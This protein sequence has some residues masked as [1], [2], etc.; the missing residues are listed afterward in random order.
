M[1]ILRSLLLLTGS[2]FLTVQQP[3]DQPVIRVNTHLVEV[4]VVAQSKNGPV[5]DLTQDDFQVFDRGKLQKIA[6]FQKN[7][8]LRSGQPL[9]PA[10]PDV[11]SN[12]S[13][14][15]P[16]S[17]PGVTIFLL[18][19]I[20]TH[21]TSQ[22]QAKKEFLKLLGQIQPDERIGIYILGNQLRVLQDFTSDS[23]RLMDAVQRAPAEI[24]RDMEN[25]VP[26]FPKRPTIPDLY[27]RIEATVD[28]AR[29]T[30]NALEA[31]A[32]HLAN[33]PGRKNLIWISSGFPLVT[34]C[35]PRPC[36]ISFSA[37]LDRATRA[38]NNANIAVYPV[39]ARGL[40][41]GA[42]LGKPPDFEGGKPSPIGFDTMEQL[43]AQTG[44]VAYHDTNNIH[45]VIAKALEDS[46]V[47]YTLGFY[48]DSVRLDSEFHPLK[49]QV[50]RPG[51]DAR[52]RK[53]YIAVPGGKP[54]P[55][56]AQQ[57][58]DALTSPLDA[59]GIAL[60]A[61][62]DRTSHQVAISIAGGDIVFD[63]DGDHWACALDMVFQQQAPDGRNSVSSEKL[64]RLKPKASE[65]AALR[66]DTMV[67]IRRIATAVLHPIW[68]TE[69]E[70]PRNLICEFSDPL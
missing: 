24:T 31:I 21:Y 9:A 15:R 7:G 63:P 64:V 3:A 12:R 29:A 49:V 42:M 66:C 46:E 69:S 36:T 37:E 39:D 40:I 19:A 27:F 4:G 59:S 55:Q 33:G 44:G 1:D 41:A 68:R 58:A 22:D 51:V 56:W 30:T 67:S 47:S 54:D 38:L 6:V 14:A 23:R 10:S 34:R 43:A 20:N 11:F 8:A 28:R 5:T 25:M 13:Q 2:A 61:R 16:D 52:Y 26:A 35:L 57:M 50:Q 70:M 60:S 18:D 53:G 48:P 17:P 45:G 65:Y 32:N 62:L